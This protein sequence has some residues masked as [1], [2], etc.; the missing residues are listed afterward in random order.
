MLVN[1]VFSSQAIYHM[2]SLKILAKVL[3][4]IDRLRMHALWISIDEGVIE[5][6]GEMSV[7]LQNKVVLEF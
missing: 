6:L 4:Q 7:S 5:W 3:T 1:S 2:G